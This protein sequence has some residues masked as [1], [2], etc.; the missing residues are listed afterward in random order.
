M[1]NVYQSPD[2]GK[3]IELLLATPITY[4]GYTQTID[5]RRKQV[6]AKVDINRKLDKIS[7]FN[8]FVNGLLEGYGTK[9]EYQEE[10]RYQLF[11]TV[12]QSFVDVTET[13]AYKILGENKYFRKDRAVKIV[14]AAKEIVQNDEF[15]WED[16]FKEA[17]DNWENGFKSDKFLKIKGIA[18]TTK[19]SKTRDYAISE[20]SYYYC[21]IDRNVSR[22]MTRTG[23]VLHGF[24]K[25]KFDYEFGTSPVD[26]YDFLKQLVLDF[27][28]QTGWAPT[29]SKGYS[30][31]E[32]DYMFWLFCSKTG[33][34]KSKPEC[35]NCP[36]KSLCLT[37]QKL[38]EQFELEQHSK[39]EN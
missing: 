10:Q 14:M 23:L 5:E 38:Y 26:N 13:N 9:G 37:Y 2:L 33:I 1:S 31:K 27:C 19:T 16:Y 15:I 30:P 32:I 7:T 36:I 6:I 28:K 25:Y 20:F 18:S 4:E 22:F 17:E 12:I 24:G 11:K 21:A 29:S 3:V 39:R 34:C 8:R 35:S